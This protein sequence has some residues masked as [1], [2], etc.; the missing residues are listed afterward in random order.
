MP[1]D[2]ILSELSAGGHA[3]ANAVWTDQAKKNLL[4]GIRRNVI[5]SKLDLVEISQPPHGSPED[6]LFSTFQKLHTAVGGAILMHSYQPAYVLPTKG[7][8]LD[9]TMGPLTKKVREAT[10]GRYALFLHV[11]DSYAGGGRVALMLTAALLFGVAIEGGKQTGFASL[12]DLETGE[13]V[14][15][16]HIART[17]GDLRNQESAQESINA[18]FMGFP[19]G[20]ECG[21]C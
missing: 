1:P 4:E 14:W 2:I 8:K 13:I 20:K 9:W 12:V 6:Q 15:F 17:S 3:E 19:L 18:L 21:T 10:Q 5:F 11:Y 7:V 16:N